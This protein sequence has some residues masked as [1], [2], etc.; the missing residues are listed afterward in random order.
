M[1]AAGGARAARSHAICV[2]TR[3]PIFPIK[4]HSAT[5]LYNF[6]ICID[7]TATASQ[8]V[9]DHRSELSINIQIDDSSTHPDMY[10]LYGNRHYVPIAALRHSATGV[11]CS[12]R[13]RGAAVQSSMLSQHQNCHRTPPRFALATATTPR[14]QRRCTRSELVNRA[15]G[16][17]LQHKNSVNVHGVSPEQDAIRH[18]T[19]ETAKINQSSSF[20]V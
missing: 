13:V 1:P 4:L 8:A 10:H 14:M 20:D 6:R 11:M 19:M 18:Q 16:L 12:R 7:H 15:K 2:G 17:L 9:A 3:R 5:K